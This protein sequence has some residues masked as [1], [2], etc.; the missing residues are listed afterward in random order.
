MLTGDEFTVKEPPHSVCAVFRARAPQRMTDSNRPNTQHQRYTT[1]LTAR[2]K[3]CASCGEMLELERADEGTVGIDD[4][5]LT[6]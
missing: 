3:I 4:R 5:K 6:E 2:S 1:H